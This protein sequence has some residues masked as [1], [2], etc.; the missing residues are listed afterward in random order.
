MA[1]LAVKKDELPLSVQEL[2]ATHQQGAAQ[3]QAKLLHRSVTAQQK[4]KVE[5]A[6]IQSARLQY[7]NGWYTYLGQL[8]E[9]L[10]KQSQAQTTTLQDLAEK[11][12]QWTSSLQE[13]NKALQ[14]QIKPEAADNVDSMETAEALADAA[15]ARVADTVSLEQA[16][17]VQREQQEQAT[18]ALLA[19]VQMA[20]EKAG[21]EAAAAAAKERDRT[22]R[23]RK[24]SENVIDV[25]A[26]P[27]EA[28]G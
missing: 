3:D 2:L 20:K 7:L 6:K 21:T 24:P 8:S 14:T 22:P 10:Q 26:V 9:L 15:E 19:A 11:E 23:R 12:L 13:A 5:L 16:L 17:Q 18:S 28:S 4:A 1:A 25:D 27:G